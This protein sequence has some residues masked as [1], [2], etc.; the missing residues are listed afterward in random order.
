MIEISELALNV[1][2]QGLQAS[3]VDRERGLRI[4]EEGDRLTLELDKPGKQDRVI[5]HNGQKVLII[6]PGFE[7]RIGDA[8]I[9]VE[10]TAEGAE[11]IMR[12]GR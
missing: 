7:A 6:D 10:E 3:H 12:S 2:F 9:D 1:L 11:I 8:F 5:S 4:K